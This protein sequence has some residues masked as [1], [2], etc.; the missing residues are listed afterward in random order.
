MGLEAIEPPNIVYITDLV[1]SNPVGG[2]DTV[3]TLD[4]HTR[5]IKNV[6]LLTFPNLNGA[7]NFTP[8]EANVL[9]GVTPGIAA[10]SKALVLDGSSNI[11]GINSLTATSLNGALTG[12]VTGNVTGNVTGDVTGNVSGTAARWAS[13]MQLSLI[14]DISGS[15]T[16]DG[17]SP[18]TLTALINNGYVKFGAEIGAVA[19]ES[20]VSVNTGTVFAAGVYYMADNNTSTKSNYFVVQTYLNGAWRNSQAFGAN[21]V[22]FVSNG[23]S[24]NTRIASLFGTQTLRYRRI[25]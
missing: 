21:P 18:V 6:L 7:V 25:Y 16:F 23:L 15:V 5:G 1:S 11:S 3:N 12:D 10:A 13:P 8:A 2:T 22:L 17:S 19:S 20:T 4:N 24:N 14:G 9:A